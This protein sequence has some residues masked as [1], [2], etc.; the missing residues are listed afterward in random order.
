MGFPTLDLH[1]VPDP[2]GLKERLGSNSIP[3]L[4]SVATHGLGVFGSLKV[5]IN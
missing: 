5:V 3:F 4:C 1:N 2:E